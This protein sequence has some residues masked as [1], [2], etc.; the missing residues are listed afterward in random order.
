MSGF[1][2]KTDCKVVTLFNV[3]N[4]FWYKEGKGCTPRLKLATFALAEKWTGAGGMIGCKHEIE[5]SLQAASDPI[6]GGFEHKL[7]TG[8]KL[9]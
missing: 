7:P 3:Y 9:A 8:G 2:S 1:M 6:F 5:A 4:S